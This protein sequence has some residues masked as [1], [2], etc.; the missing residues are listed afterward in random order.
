MQHAYYNT[1][2]TFALELYCCSFFYHIPNRH[3]HFLSYVVDLALPFPA[4]LPYSKNYRNL[5]YFPDSR[6][7]GSSACAAA[8]AGRSP[9]GCGPQGDRR[10]RGEGGKGEGDGHDEEEIGIVV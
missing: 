1:N 9:G 3:S 5:P 4:K 10:R 6:P 7:R 8:T 2:K